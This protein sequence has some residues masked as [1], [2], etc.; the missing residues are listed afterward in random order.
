MLPRRTPTTVQNIYEAYAAA[1]EAWDSAGLDVA[2]AGEDCEKSLWYSLRWASE[3]TG[4]TGQDLRRQ[5]STA[6]QRQRLVDDLARIGIAIASRQAGVELAD[7]HVRGKI[8]G[9]ARGVPEAPKTE[10]LLEVKAVTAKVYNKLQR[11]KVKVARPTHFAACQLFMHALGLTR[12]LYV[13]VNTDDDS[14][15]SERLDYD[16]YFASSLAARLK[17]IINMDRPPMGVC[18]GTTDFRA[19][20]CKHRSTCMRGELMR[21]TCRSCVHAVAGQLGVWTCERHERELTLDEQ[22]QACPSHLFIPETVAGEQ[23]DYLAET[24]T[25]VYKMADGTIWKNGAA[26][27]D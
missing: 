26:T 16:V 2:I 5:E 6:A 14:L 19:T 27:V 21:L 4:R 13:A 20:M 18:S 11:H 7:G 24:E 8:A 10:H 12:C 23:I 22:K 25:V 9:R 3:A 17:R 15:Y 1:S